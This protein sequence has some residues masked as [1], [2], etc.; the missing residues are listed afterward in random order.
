MKVNWHIPTPLPNAYLQLVQLTHCPMGIRAAN[1]PLHKGQQQLTYVHFYPCHICTSVLLFQAVLWVL[2]TSHKDIA[3]P[4]Q[5]A[6]CDNQRSTQPH[7]PATASSVG[8]LFSDA[9][10]WT[11]S[12]SRH[13]PVYSPITLTTKPCCHVYGATNKK[14]LHDLKTKFV[15]CPHSPCSPKRCPTLQN[16]QRRLFAKL[17][18][19]FNQTRTTA[20]SRLACSSVWG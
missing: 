3:P 1:S 19:A 14:L 2:L 8:L 13:P 18:K 16:H 6:K 10:R 12:P 5:H 4:F 11:N 15:G 20:Y 17:D 7:K 9:L